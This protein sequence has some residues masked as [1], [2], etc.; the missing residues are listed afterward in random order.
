MRA[1]FLCVLAAGL[2]RGA[3][4]GQR[5]LDATLAL[6]E[7]DVAALEKMDAASHCDAVCTD[8]TWTDSWAQKCDWFECKG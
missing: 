1:L 2:V 3:P 8:G 5:S 6:I 7:R 4:L